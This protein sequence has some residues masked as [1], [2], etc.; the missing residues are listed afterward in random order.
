MRQIP[1]LSLILA[2]LLLT[3]ACGATAGSGSDAA[4]AQSAE[5][6]EPVIEAESTT[7]SSEPEPTPEPQDIPLSEEESKLLGVWEAED[8]SIVAIRPRGNREQ[9]AFTF[10]AIYL[11]PQSGEWI[12]VTRD[13]TT[14]AVSDGA[15]IIS[16]KY[17]CPDPSNPEGGMLV[18][19]E[20]RIE[21]DPGSDTIL[22]VSRHPTT[23]GEVM[24][25][26]NTLTR[27]DMDIDDASIDWA[28]Y[29]EI[30]PSRK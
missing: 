16:D 22:H 28:G 26:S 20:E 13:E 9:D 2:V 10:D 17:M 5:T 30:H 25:W 15:Y 27:S 24:E 1:M 12:K 21:Y 19:T 7:Q 4:P 14:F 29:Y 8:G 18:E 3:T 11:E 23:S 6:T